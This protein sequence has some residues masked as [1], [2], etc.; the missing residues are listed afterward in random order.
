M[1]GS[2]SGLL[3]ISAAILVAVILF[4]ARKDLTSDSSKPSDFTSV[5]K[6][7][8]KRPVSVRGERVPD[9][10]FTVVIDSDEELNSSSEEESDDEDDVP[11]SRENT[12]RSLRNPMIPKLSLPKRKLTPYAK[13]S[14]DSDDDEFNDREIDDLLNGDEDESEL[15]SKFSS[16]DY[17]DEAVSNEKDPLS[18]IH[19][20]PNVSYFQPT[21]RLLSKIGKKISTSQSALTHRLGNIMGLALDEI[22][23]N[24]GPESPMTPESQQQKNFKLSLPDHSEND[25]EENLQTRT[26]NNSIFARLSLSFAPQ[27]SAPDSA[28][29]KNEKDGSLEE[30]QLDSASPLRRQKKHSKLIE[31]ADSD[32]ERED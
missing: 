16:D 31:P 7:R 30:I 2:I 14:T 4:A 24:D 15:P 8:P 21:A 19:T 28:R 18:Q 12:Q 6:N 1:I 20:D 22:P 29:L 9:E 25:S 26:R 27:G 11:S 17:I 5:F 13:A 10:V 3:L 32:D 23:K